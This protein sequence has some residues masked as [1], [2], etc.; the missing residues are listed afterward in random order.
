MP[1]AHI[2]LLVT[3]KA[4]PALSAKYGEVVCVAG[5]QLE[6][7]QRRWV[8]LYPLK[9]R[10][11]P[12]A[13]R[14]KKYDIISVN[15]TPASDGRPESY[16]PDPDTVRVLDHLSTRDNWAARMEIIRPLVKR[17]LCEIKRLQALDRT[18][19]GIFKPASVS[20]FLMV[21]DQSDWDAQKRTALDQL[22]LLDTN[23]SELEKIPS[24]FRYRF[25][26]EDQS[27]GGHDLSVIDWEVGAAYRSWRSRFAEHELKTKLRQKWLDEMCGPTKDTHFIVGNQHQHRQA[28]LVLGVVWPK[29]PG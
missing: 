13:A 8:R 29:L 24:T 26:C 14:F 28:F 25:R 19:L 12:F 20:G 22:N 16:R 6:P 27:C 10:A 18:S 7:G 11:L 15:V 5:I 4:Y 1:N 17:S 2:K 9:F 3:V 23:H 21:A